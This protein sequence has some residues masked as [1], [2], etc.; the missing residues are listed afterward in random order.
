MIRSATMRY[1]IVGIRDP[2]VADFALQHY[3]NPVIFGNLFRVETAIERTATR[4]YEG[5]VEYEYRNV[6]DFTFSFDTTGGTQHL[7]Q[8]YRT[9]GRY[10][11]AGKTA[12]N[13]YGAIGVNDRDIAGCEVIIPQLSFSMNRTTNGILNIE[14]IKNLSRMTGRINR[15]PFLTF[16]PGEVLFE[17]ASGSQKFTES[18]YPQ[19]DLTY[20]FRV[21]PNEANL[22]IGQEGEE[23]GD[24]EE[25]GKITVGFKR[26][27]DYFWVQ[28]EETE[29][30]DASVVS[31]QPIAA[32][33]ERVYKTADLNALL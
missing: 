33:V 3:S 8:S 11:P 32:F 19:F 23:G 18:D 16:E 21:S 13:H 24:D 22:I 25:S 9:V 6:D 1:N 26:G 5:V 31:K 12:P 10:A 17:G 29:D 20:K 7:T 2:E 28:Y 30:E 15:L 4:G 27:W 14:F